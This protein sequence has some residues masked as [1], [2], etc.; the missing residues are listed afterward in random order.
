[1]RLLF[2]TET[3]PFPLDSGGRIKTFNTLRMLAHEHQVH[4]HALVR[5]EARLRYKS[6]LAVHCTQVT[7]HYA[8][9]STIGEIRSA[10]TGFA[11]G[12]PFVIARQFHQT[13]MD[14]IVEDAR[15]RRFDAVYC[16]HLSMFEYARR[17]ALPI[18]MDAHNVEFEIVRRH[19]ITIG[20][21]PLRLV[22]ER[23]W[24]SLRRYEMR[25]YPRC[26]LIF[27]VS[28]VDAESIRRLGGAANAVVALPISVDAATISVLDLP[29]AP[30]MLFVGGLR[31]P[32]NADAVTYF[33]DAIL[34]RIRRVLP[35]ARVTVV[36]EVPALLAARL[37][38]RE[39]VRLA[40]YV[41]DVA[42]MFAASRVMVVPLRSG[43]GMRVKIL[44][45]FARSLPVVTTSVGAEGLDGRAG[46]EWL[47]GDTPEAF[48]EEVV[49]VLQ[50]AQLAERLRSAGRN[51]VRRRYEVSVVGAQL[52]EVIRGAEFGQP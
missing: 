24:R 2:L 9:R 38:G 16:D 29:A 4:C 7:L 51:L 18:M 45:A 44:D 48:A 31:W 50:D 23:E 5:D 33:V 30:E 22:Y 49:R 47:A 26:R 39:G 10:A 40:G 41:D 20:A 28:D 35:Q 27:S 25:A 19:A 34:P 3:I 6:H 46:E 36:G 52:L 32:P 42:P 17:L 15:T 12:L 37:N 8:P 1:M 14:R 21:R 43:S 11:R 13:V